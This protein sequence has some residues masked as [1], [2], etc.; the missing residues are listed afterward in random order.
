MKSLGGMF[1]KFAEYAPNFTGPSTP[2]PTIK[3]VI[4]VWEKTSVDK[5]DGGS[6]VSHYGNKQWL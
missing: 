4:S 2:E 6:F 1:G 5:G 3:D